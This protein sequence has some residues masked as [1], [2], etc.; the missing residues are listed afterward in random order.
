[1]QKKSLALLGVFLIGLLSIAASCTAEFDFDDL[2]DWDDLKSHF[3]YSQTLTE[4][5]QFNNQQ[6]L[7][8]DNGVGSIK[9]ETGAPN[10]IL[11]EVKK[12]TKRQED[13][14][15]LY[16]DVQQNANR[17]EI[18][19][20]HPKYSKH[21]SIKWKIDFVLK[22]PT[23]MGL[24]IDQGVGKIEIHNYAG[25]TSSLDLGV[26]SARVENSQ[27]AQ[28]D[29]DLGVGDADLHYLESSEIS[30]SV[31]TGDLHLGLRPDA[32]FTIDA[33]VGMGDLSVHGF[34]N[35]N[36]SRSSFIS[37]SVHGTVGLGANTMNLHVG[38]GDLSVSALEAPLP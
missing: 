7:H 35:M 22:V 1:M 25:T 18:S 20:K 38:V 6:T 34:Q 36:L 3:P 9:I 29:L 16:L 32:S 17:I 13:L 19:I 33:D 37:H 23:G 31:G 26:G 21:S 14:A 5:I 30:A 12:Y 2:E 24:K 15:K 11:L 28:F 10:T 4:T 8:L 27:F